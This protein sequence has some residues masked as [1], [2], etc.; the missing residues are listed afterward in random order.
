MILNKIILEK[1]QLLFMTGCLAFIFYSSATEA[2]KQYGST[3]F[4]RGDYISHELFSGVWQGHED[5]YSSLMLKLNQNGNGIKG[6]Y[7]YITQNG[8][9]IDCPADNI[10]NLS[11]IIKG[12]VAE[13]S[14][15]SSFGGKSGKSKLTIN[16]KE[17]RWTLL[18]EPK[19]GVSYAPTHYTLTR[20]TDKNGSQSESKVFI[21]DKFTINIKN[22]CGT[23]LM[24]CEEMLYV[25]VRNSDGSSISLYGK[26]ILSKNNGKVVGA[27]FSNGNIIYH[28][29]YDK[30]LLQV[31][32]NGKVI[33]NQT[34]IWKNDN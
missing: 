34:G 22:R 16:G 14:F 28:V 15:D 10:N 32:K 3:V 8:N 30:P 6:Q 2:S 23:F 9:R 11:G 33:V 27:E 21:N 19:D 24:P 1:Y 5:E 26:T 7:C 20:S 17:M 4:N 31:T 13:I 18:A 29:Y 25:G 12:S